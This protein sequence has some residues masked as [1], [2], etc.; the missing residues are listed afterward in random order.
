MT[1]P[2]RPESTPVRLTILAVVVACLFAALF[3][4]LWYLQVI[5]G[6][7]AQAAAQNQGVRI[8]YTDAQGSY[9]VQGSLFEKNST[10][11]LAVARIAM[12]YPLTIAAAGFAWFVVRRARHRLTRDYGPF[13]ATPDRT[14]P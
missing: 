13:D 7:Q 11:W 8:V 9:V 12:G 1:T 4:R 2:A 5:S 10:G 14:S 6:T 3:A